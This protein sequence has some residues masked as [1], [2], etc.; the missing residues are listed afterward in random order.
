MKTE[1]VQKRSK[2]FFQ[3]RANL[4]IVLI[5]IFAFLVRLKYL[6]FSQPLWWDEA[7][8]L[9]IAKHW[10]FGI[11]FEVSLIRPYL[12]P[13]FVA[14]L[15][16]IG[17]GEGILRIIEILIS[18][19][20]VYL[21]FLIGRKLFSAKVGLI[22]AFIMSFFYLNLFYT[23]R[24]LV[25]MPSM[26]LSLLTIYLFWEGYVNKKSHYYIW[27]MGAV[28]GLNYLLR[29]PS[30]LTAI[31]ILLYLLLTERLR[32]LKNKHL[33]IAAG[34]CVALMIPYFIYFYVTFDK[35]PIIEG[36]TYGFGHGELRFGYYLSI[37][38]TILQSKI[39]FLTNNLPFLHLFLLLF[40][41]GFGSMIFNLFL[42]YDL[43]GKDKKLKKFVLLLFWI[44]LP[45]AFF[46]MIQQAEDRYLFYIY[47]AMFIV[48]SYA[49]VN[50]AN[51]FKKYHKFAPHAIIGLVLLFGMITHLQFADALIKSKEQSYIQLKQTGEWIKANSN[52]EDKVISCAQ[53][54][55]THYGER[56]IINFPGHEE[57]FMDFLRKEKPKFIVL[58]ALERSHDWT[59][60][61]PQKNPDKVK[62]VQAYFFDRERTKPASIIYLVNPELFKENATISL[63]E[64]ALLKE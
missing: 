36:V 47:P 2:G 56:E 19:A 22:A 28:I 49:L 34:I 23:A 48:I 3:D 57:E 44:V 11:P 62:P 10:A 7:E 6:N 12:F 27:A 52:P 61:W 42:G 32:F 46:S 51:Y 13:F 64:E 1:N 4:I 5:L 63:D 21:T 8:Y 30:A 14:G 35:I 43:L 45:Y 16:K 58:T 20:G 9:S 60:G 15:F 55:L 41:Y 33:W 29:F 38:P 54:Q 37:M 26:V 53:P 31:G 18:L 24:I 59:Y 39:P 40:I 25:G 50:L 17:F